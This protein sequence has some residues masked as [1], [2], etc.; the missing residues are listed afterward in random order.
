MLRILLSLFFDG[1]L[2]VS[3]TQE[4]SM[5]Q[6]YVSIAV[7]LLYDQYLRHDYKDDNI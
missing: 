3:F 6:W 5:C 2:F 7:C 1:L 4:H